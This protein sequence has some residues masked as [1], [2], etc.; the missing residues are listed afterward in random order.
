MDWMGVPSGII[1]ITYQF[2]Q[3]Q[4]VYNCSHPLPISYGNT[5]HH[6]NNGYHGSTGYHSTMVAMVILVTMETVGPQGLMT[7]T[8]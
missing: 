4:N 3:T 5:S 2:Q 8:T 7:K 1:S 6:G